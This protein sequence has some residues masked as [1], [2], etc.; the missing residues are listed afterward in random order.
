VSVDTLRIDLSTAR[1]TKQRRNKIYRLCECGETAHDSSAEKI[2]GIWYT[3]Y[4]CRNCAAPVVG[5]ANLL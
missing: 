4:K 1:R 3:V 5:P 2:G